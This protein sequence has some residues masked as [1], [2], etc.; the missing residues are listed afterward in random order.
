MKLVQFELS[1]DIIQ[2]HQAELTDTIKQALYEKDSSI[3]EKLDFE[4]DLIFLEPSLFCYF[5]SAIDRSKKIPLYQSVYGYM[6]ESL[7]PQELLL[8]SDLFGLINLPNMGYIKTQPLLDIN[9]KSTE[10]VF[11]IIPN[12]FID[13]SQ[14]RI[15]KHPT[16]EL[17]LK[18]DILFDEPIEQTLT[19][20][21]AALTDA[22]LFLQSNLPEFWQV[23][24]SVTREF[25]L[26]SSPNQNS[27]AGISHHGTAY[28]NTEKKIQ[29]CVFYIDDISHQCG[30]IIFN[31]LTLDVESYLRVPKN[32]PIR[33]FVKNKDDNRNVYGAFHGLFTYTCILYSMDR[34]L[35]KG[36]DPL[37]VSEALGR[38][39]FYLNKFK[40]DLVNLDNPKILT[41][42]G[43]SFHTQFQASYEYIYAKYNRQIVGFD[44]S[45]QPYTFQYDLFKKV[46]GISKQTHA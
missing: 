8:K 1:Q 15:C 36:D 42:E 38:I 24:E 11:Q 7:R 32:H 12:D 22:C 23:I 46:N 34:I 44:Y 29:T 35:E 19:K 31:T 4:N 43:M 14:I 40:I 9:F 25:V 26:F 30:H 27:F 20:N 3:F 39:G 16:D 18:A 37:M 10:I 6:E 28:F 2:L 21:K 13:N 5:L 33:E 45:N 17:G 41:D